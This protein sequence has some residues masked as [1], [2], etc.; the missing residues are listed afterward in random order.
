MEHFNELLLC[1]NDFNYFVKK[2]VKIKDHSKGI[3]PL[4]L[5]EY[6]KDFLNTCQV[7]RNVIAVKFRQSGLLTVHLLKSI[8]ECMFFENRRFFYASKTDNSAFHMGKL[9]DQFIDHFP[10]WM[11]P[12]FV[13]NTMK[14]KVFALTDSWIKFGSIKSV[15]GRNFTDLIIE[16]AAFIEGMQENWESFIHSISYNTKILLL[17]NIH[18]TD[19]WFHQTWLN[20]ESGKNNFTTFRADYKLKPEFSSKDFD[21]KVIQQIGEKLFRKQYLCE[22]ISDQPQGSVDLRK[23]S[24]QDLKEKT[25]KL[26]D[27]YSKEDKLLITE[28][29]NRIP[30]KSI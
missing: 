7:K 28:L 15:R 2:Y 26:I 20:A 8:W 1:R 12:N 4:E 21:K 29:M 11:K 10:T 9:V 14:E 19:D 22:F 16:D 30:E 6:Q 5:H 23:L 13:A 24:N 3:I 17:S 27:A 18:G 25:L